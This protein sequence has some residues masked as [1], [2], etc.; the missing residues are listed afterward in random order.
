MELQYAGL[1]HSLQTAVIAALLAKL[2]LFGG[3]ATG[4]KQRQTYLNSAKKIY[5]S[6]YE[7]FKDSIYRIAS[8]D[9]EDTVVVPVSLLPELRKLG[10][11]VL[12]FPKAIDKLME[13]KYTKMETDS[14]LVIQSVRSDLTP[15]LSRMNQYVRE[16]IDTCIPKYLPACDD[17]SEV[18]IYK[19]LVDIIAQVSGRVFVGPE[20][21]EDP[22]YLDCA[23]NYTLDMID[24]VTAIKKLRPLF[25]P[26]TAPRCPEIRRL[27]QREKAAADMLQP[28]V[29]QRQ[30]AAKDPDW[31]KPDDM[32][33]WMMDR[34]ASN[35]ISVQELATC[36]LGLIFAAIHTT[37]LT[38][39]NILYTLASTPEYIDPLREE[40]RSVI[41]EHDGDI[42]TKALQQMEK[43]DSYMKEVK[44]VYPPGM[45]SFTRRVLKGITLSNGQYIPPG[46]I[47]EVPSQAV[48]NDSTIYPDSATFDGFRHYKLR[49]NG[50]S[51]DHARNQFV[52][53][54]EQNLA[55][56]YGRHACPGRFFAANEIKMIVAKMILDY[57]I[58]LPEGVTE[59]YAQIEMGRTISPN[60]T[61]TLMFKKLE[62]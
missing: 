28:M 43:L 33:Q 35:N 42:T 17:W 21:C 56:G 37:S 16:E 57:E 23:T 4:E 10:D 50:S 54:N 27:R 25:R 40:I 31:I 41:A 7:K 38:A 60:P 47:I 5:L 36:Q 48:Y 26:F 59:R 2:P 55:F 12:S 58:K 6:G 49:R 53:T 46:V 11:D 19:A 44:R 34:G 13:T 29:R 20:L 18:Y 1:A 30:E 39:T 8:S 3:P 52:T 62:V 45:T 51:T 24:S 22:E 9:G 61:K 15:A 14:H 32:T